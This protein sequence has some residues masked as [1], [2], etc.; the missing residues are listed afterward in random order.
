MGDVGDEVVAQPGERE[1]AAEQLPDEKGEQQADEDGETG[2]PKVGAGGCRG[3]EPVDASGGRDGQAPAGHA[4]PDRKG[5]R[6]G[7]RC[8]AGREYR[9]AY[10]V[11]FPGGEQTLE[12][13]DQRRGPEQEDGG[14]VGR[15]ILP[16]VGIRGRVEPGL[17][18][19][20]LVCRAPGGGEVLG[21]KERGRV[22]E[23]TGSSRLAKEKAALG[24]GELRAAVVRGVGA[25]RLL[26]PC[27]ARVVRFGHELEGEQGGAGRDQSSLG[28]GGGPVALVGG[29]L[30]E[31]G[32]RPFR[33]PGPPQAACLGE[34]R[35]G[36][37]VDVVAGCGELRVARGGFLRVCGF[38]RGD[39]AGFAAQAGH[40]GARAVGRVECLAGTIEHHRG[41]GHAGAGD[42]AEAGDGRGGGIDRS[43]LG[44]RGIPE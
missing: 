23:L 11:R 9:D 25:K 22:L 4:C 12:S 14:L 39:L 10:V 40:D 15:R 1:L 8:V 20:V 13:R 34:E 32:D 30:C 35:A 7:G 18:R 31:E 21:E 43:Q 5:S 28:I 38:Q 44:G 42:F 19:D 16:D 26:Q 41:I 6:P 29:E 17:A 36:R 2:D 27:P 37:G 3:A 24:R 33:L